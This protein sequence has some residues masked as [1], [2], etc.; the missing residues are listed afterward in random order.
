[1][2]STGQITTHMYS[3]KSEETFLTEIYFQDSIKTLYRKHVV[4]Q[5]ESITITYL[6]A[7][8]LQE[9]KCVLNRVLT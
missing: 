9:F 5:E 1:M 6:E 2:S 7:A 4:E 8:D 3:E